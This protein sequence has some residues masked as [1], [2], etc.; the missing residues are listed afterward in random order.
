MFGL[1]KTL[2][3]VISEEVGR[4]KFLLHSCNKFAHLRYLRNNIEE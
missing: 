3:E 1:N 4:F 2:S